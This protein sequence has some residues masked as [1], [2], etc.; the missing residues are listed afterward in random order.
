MDNHCPQHYNMNFAYHVKIKKTGKDCFYLEIEQK[1]KKGFIKI[2]QRIHISK[3]IRK[4]VRFG[5]NTQNPK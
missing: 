2:I 4:A 1:T 5:T 3:K